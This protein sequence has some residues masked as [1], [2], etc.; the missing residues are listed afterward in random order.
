MKKAFAVL[1]CGLLALSLT[2]CG[3]VPDNTVFS[4]DDLPG[5][6][7]GVQE[8]TTG[9]MLASDYEEQGATV[10]RYDTGND[11]IQ[12]LKQGK[13]DCVIIDNEPAKSFVEA[14]K[15]LKILEEPFANEE[16]AIAIQ[17]GNTELTNKI[18]DA[19]A[20]L[21]ENGTMDNIIKN[22]IGDA[23]GET[24]YVS[25][26]NVDR[27]NGT[28]VMA[29]NAYFPPYEYYENDQVV[30]LDVD[31]AQAICDILGMELQVEDMSFDSIIPAVSSGKADVG[32]AG[33]TV[34]E[35][36]LKNVDFSDSYATGVQ[37]IVVREK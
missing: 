5:K 16:Y 11:A 21:K 9:D 7:I 18:N 8:Q 20:Q 28:L 4:A 17:K 15:G 27:S 14:N 32:I 3:S 19:L 26:E 29:T 2:A 6:K 31:M 36:R 35:T 25:P 12:A 22:Y 13:I 30:G 23:R 24:P 1:M 34:D 37:V 33:M 10:E